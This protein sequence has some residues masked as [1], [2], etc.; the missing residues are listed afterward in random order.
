MAPGMASVGGPLCS[1]WASVR[2]NYVLKYWLDSSVVIIR[3]HG[4]QLMR[5]PVF[6][7]YL[8]V[9]LEPTQGCYLAHIWP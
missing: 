5:P 9:P 7:D 6:H 4:P 3:R 8:T 1:F 2:V